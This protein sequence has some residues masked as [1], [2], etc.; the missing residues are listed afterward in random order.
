[1]LWRFLFLMPDFQV[2]EPDMGLTL[3]SLIEP[4]RYNY[5]PAC[6]S[7]TW[8]SWD[9]IIL[10]VHPL[11]TLSVSSLEPTK[12]YSTFTTVFF[13]IDGW[14]AVNYGFMFSWEEV[15]S[16][17]STDI[18][19]SSWFSSLFQN[20]GSLASVTWI[21][22]IFLSSSSLIL[23][24]IWSALFPVHSSSYWVLLLQN[25]CLSFSILI[26]L[27]KYSFCFLALFLRLLYFS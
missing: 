8:G 11:S 19:T 12:R 17:Y 20:L 23:S 25:T 7:L 18:L 14:S 10:Q 22:F 5:S 15:S 16:R 21:I 3:L 13:F 1:M 9:P 27:V 4:V 2:G 6:G 24:S 26:S